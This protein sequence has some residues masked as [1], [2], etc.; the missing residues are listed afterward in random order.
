MSM[1]TQ[2]YDPAQQPTMNLNGHSRPHTAEEV[3]GRSVGDLMRQ[4]TADLSTL[5][6]QEVELA[7]AEIREEGKKA[8]KAAG[9]FGGAGFGGYMVALFLS[10]ALWGGLSNVM[11]AGWAALIVAVLWGVVA[12]VLYSMGKK[13][14]ER[15]R[16]LKRTNDTVHRIPGALK[17][18]PEGVT[19]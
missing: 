7:K 17:P 2:G 1:P 16:G 4:V 10:L 12:A 15:V 14:A 11:D 18:H 13:N 19:R 3:T 9:F 8:G 5:M 6:R